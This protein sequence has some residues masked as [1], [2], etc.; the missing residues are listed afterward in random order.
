L[1]ISSATLRRAGHSPEAKALKIPRMINVIGE[2][3]RLMMIKELVSMMIESRASPRSNEA[4]FRSLDCVAVVG[5]VVEVEVRRG[6]VS[7]GTTDGC[8]GPDFLLMCLITA[9]IYQENVSGRFSVC[10]DMKYQVTKPS[11]K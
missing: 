2:G 1:Y 7:V 6:S 4:E 9:E 5:C 3:V 10:G 8:A 11:S